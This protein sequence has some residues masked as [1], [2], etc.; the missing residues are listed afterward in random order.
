MRPGGEP[1]RFVES[2]KSWTPIHAADESETHVS[3]VNGEQHLTN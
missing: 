2:Q 3:P 1:G